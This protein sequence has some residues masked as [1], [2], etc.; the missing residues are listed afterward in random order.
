MAET[1]LSLRQI[2][3]RYGGCAALEVDSLDIK[4]GELLALIGPNGAGKSTLLRVMGF[5]QSPDAGSVQFGGAAAGAQSAL[6]LRRRI[7]T[8]FQEPLLLND[9]L[10][11]NAALGL[12]L[13]GMKQEE[14]ARRTQPWLE[15]LKIAHLSKRS[16]RTLSSGEAQR[17]SLARAL[18]LEPELLLL[19]EPFGALDAG[20]R[21]S[22]LSDFQRIVKD[23]GMTT[24]LVTHDRND[25]YLLADRAAVLIDGRMAQLGSRDE[26]FS[27]PATEAVAAIVGIENRLHGQAEDADGINS[28]IRIG[29]ALVVVPRKF[30][31]G[32]KVVL[33]IRAEDMRLSRVEADPEHLNHLR[34]ALTEVIPGTQQLRCAVAG[35]GFDLMVALAPRSCPGGEFRKGIAVNVFF[36]PASVHVIPADGSF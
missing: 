23:T 2:V 4:S 11:Q 30:P 25:A 29:E 3:V 34:G 17:A 6:S 20:G 15:R 18:V 22:L 7:A 21:E 10:Y 33:C 24:V 36:D 5:L 26:I 35:Q 9:T 32:T 1:I 8:V 12:Q 16:A 28:R 19:D 27:H 31:R 14:I 13:R